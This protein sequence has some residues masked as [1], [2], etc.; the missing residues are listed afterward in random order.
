MKQKK[1]PEQ[2]L[3]RQAFPLRLQYD[4]LTGR[5]QEL[6]DFLL[7]SPS[8]LADKPSSSCYGATDIER[9]RIL[10][11]LTQERFLPFQRTVSYLEYKLA[12]LL[13]CP[14]DENYPVN[15]YA[16]RG[17]SR[18][19]DGTAVSS[20]PSFPSTN[21]AS[22][23]MRRDVLLRCPSQTR[24]TPAYLGRFAKSSGQMSLDVF[25]ELSDILSFSQSPFEEHPSRF[26][27]S[28]LRPDTGIKNRNGSSWTNAGEKVI[29]SIHQSKTESIQEVI[30]FHN[31]SNYEKPFS[32]R[33]QVLQFDLTETTIS[34][35]EQQDKCFSSG[36][37]SAALQQLKEDVLGTRAGMEDFMEFL[38]N[39]LGSHLLNFWIDCEDIMDCTR[40]LEAT[41]SPQETQL[42]FSSAFR[43]IQAKYRLAGPPAF[44]DHLEE[45][46]GEEETAFASLSRKQYDALRRLRSYWV[47]RFL[48]HYQRIRQ[49]RFEPS[50][51]VPI[52]EELFWSGDFPVSL[53]MATVLPALGDPKEMMNYMKRNK[54]WR[55]MKSRNGTESNRRLGSLKDSFETLTTIRFLEAL[56]C[57]LG[58][59]D[60]FLHYLTRF[61]D[62]QKINHLLLWKKLK[63]YEDAHKNQAS[64]S[65]IQNIA[66]QIFHMFLATCTEC[67][68]ELSSNMLDYIQHLEGILSTGSGDL[69]F[70]A[71][72]PM[73]QYVLPILG[74][75]WL[76]YVRHEVTTYLEYCVPMSHSD[77]QN[78]ESKDH[79]SNQERIGRIKKQKPNTYT[80]GSKERRLHRKG[81]KK[82]VVSKSPIGVVSKSPSISSTDQGSSERSPVL[83]DSPTPQNV[84]DFLSNP[85]ILN[86]YK[87]AA[88]KMQNMELQMVLGLLQDMEA[89]LEVPAN[90]KQ[91]NCAVKFLEMW[92]KLGGLRSFPKELKKRIKEEV[93]QGKITNVTWNEIQLLLRSLVDPSFEQFWGE[94]S[95]GLKKYGLVPSQIPEER[96]CK[97]EP[98]LNVIAGKVALRHMRH[99]EVQDASAATAKPTREDKD[100]FWESLKEA[101]EGWPTVEMLHFVKHLQV[102]GTPVLESGLH[103]LLEVQ[104]FKNAHHDRPDMT[105]LKKKVLVIR[106]CF[107]ASQIEPRLQVAVDNK[108]LG[109]AIRAAE[110]ALQKEI[111]PPSLFDSLKDSVSSMLMPYWA[112]FQ[113]H[114]L[115]R[116]VASAQRVPVL[117]NQLLLQKRQ[118]RLNESPSS[119]RL[120]PLQQPKDDNG[121]KSQ[122]GF[123]YSFSVSEG[124]IVQN[125]NNDILN[126]SSAVFR[127]M[128]KP[129]DFEF[130]ALPI[131]QC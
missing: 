14:L 47:P 66:W 26:Q 2:S 44:Q 10:R 28:R 60:G 41:V 113:K 23:G 53:L 12:K 50:S 115:K 31:N 106:D 85:V 39:T 114:W 102:Y 4:R 16:I 58:D 67:N 15:R 130:P 121:S 123:I 22:P 73:V 96:W 46:M 51:E 19:S 49:L 8:H 108:R 92:N 68:S 100:S 33:Q 3:Q 89:C 72:Q 74:E 107:L 62:P 99:R 101:A 56:M 25:L 38:H 80:H 6:D 77:V 82:K 109:R 24:S 118:A 98:F 111:P 112:A 104:K 69:A 59:G 18:Q 88:C 52:E 124:L 122:D 20:I 65:E 35:E 29:S 5:L 110:Q 86:V 126:I 127:S 9:E 57:D 79:R 1:V 84:Q 63:C 32:G 70:S 93:A 75:A 116:S 42:F 34:K 55:T 27:L 13:V 117:R 17:Y 94:M 131:H 129:N 11:W 7:E 128:N 30:E 120:P 43:D 91:V 83:Q 103:F 37:G 36:S 95:E 45:S 125:P 78:S 105:L 61:E 90:E 76:H 40:H 64:P 87:K 54:G 119:L 81:G 21:Q 97:L 71:F 48:I